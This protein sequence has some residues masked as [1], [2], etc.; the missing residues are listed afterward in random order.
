MADTQYEAIEERDSP[1]LKVAKAHGFRPT[2]T[3]IRRG[4][5]A[6]A[7][8]S[9]L[10]VILEASVT[11][12]V[13][14]G[15]RFLQYLILT[16]FIYLALKSARDHYP[17]VG[18]FQEG[19]QIGAGISVVSA[20]TVILVNLLSYLLGGAVTLEKYSHGNE[21]FGEFLSTNGIL[22]FEIFVFGMI[23]TFIWLQY[24]KMRSDDGADEATKA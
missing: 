16:A 11:E 14:Q 13:A 6:G 22:L 7:L 4:I 1:S 10:L 9:I 3:I 19:I 5:E 12:D 15:L 8:M 24:L 2:Y 18:F 20:A 17:A 23:I 21:S